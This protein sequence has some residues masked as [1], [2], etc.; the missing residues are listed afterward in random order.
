MQGCPDIMQSWKPD[1]RTR[2][3]DVLLFDRFSNLCLANAVEPLRATNSISRRPLYRWRFL[4][5]EAAPVTSSSGL[6]VMPESALR[7]SEGGD[8]LIVMPSYD[9]RSHANIATT[10]ALRAAARGRYPTLIGMDTGSW[11]LATAGLLDGRRATIHWDEYDSLAETFPEVQVLRDRF[12]IDGNRLSCGGVTTALDLILHLIREHHGAMLSL[13]VAAMFMHGIREPPWNFRMTPD[14]A[15]HGAV[16]LMRRNIENPLPIPEIAR[17]SAMDR[18]RLESLFSAETGCTPQVIYKKIRLREARR[19]L[20]N[21]NQTIA[22]IATR[23]GY[24]NAASLARAFGGEFG[25]TPSS[26]RRG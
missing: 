12:V 20:E 24:V 17:R 9:F 4:G 10:R 25:R 15:I 21:T 7:N 14:A 5:I 19:L 18:K 16:S 23:C 2:Q 6:P 3:I 22:E 11:L 1:E 26:L 8:Y 13:E